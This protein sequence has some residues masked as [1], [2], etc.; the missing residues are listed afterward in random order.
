MRTYSI[1]KCAICNK[2]CKVLGKHIKIHG[3]TPEEYY[4]EYRS[5]SESKICKLLE[6]SNSV[7]F[8]NITSGYS[9]FCS[10]SCCTKNAHKDP[11]YSESNS[12]RMK[13]RNSNPEFAKAHSDRLSALHKGPEYAKSHAIKF[14]AM[15]MKSVANKSNE[16][17]LIFYIIKCDRVLKIGCC[18]YKNNLNHFNGRYG[19][20]KEYNPGDYKLFIGSVEDVLN[21]EKFIK[22]SYVPVVTTEFFD[23]NLYNTILKSIPNTLIPLNP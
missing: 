11:E 23:I 10:S 3:L 9:D 13:L 14:S 5:P 7:S 17:S 22:E 21:F 20:I 6:C 16:N 4:N 1:V 2:D 19:K 12:E 18:L 8:N 15:S